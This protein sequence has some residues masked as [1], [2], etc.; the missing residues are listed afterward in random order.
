MA[1]VILVLAD[2][3]NRGSQLPL[4]IRPLLWQGLVEPQQSFPLTGVVL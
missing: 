3:I 1:K 2:N 4:S